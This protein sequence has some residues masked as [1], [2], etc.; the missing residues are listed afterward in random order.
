ME[1]YW[2]QKFFS[3]YIKIRNSLNNYA[4]NAIKIIYQNNFFITFY[5]FRQF[6]YLQL[7]FHNKLRLE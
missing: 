4:Q 1:L 7:L 5:N 3:D 6:I 2:R